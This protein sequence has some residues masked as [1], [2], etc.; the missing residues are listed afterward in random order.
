M[1]EG[2]ICGACSKCGVKKMHIEFGW[3][4]LKERDSWEDLGI[5]KGRITLKWILKN[6]MGSVDWANLAQDR[7][8]WRPV[9][10]TV[11]QFRFL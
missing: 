6:E 7:D 9:V 4:K 11:T 5:H 3:G 10:Y 8:E 2:E 1:E